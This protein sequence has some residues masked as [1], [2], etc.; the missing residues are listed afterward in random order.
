M[1]LNFFYKAG[2]L[3]VFFRGLGEGGGDSDQESD[4]PRHPDSGSESADDESSGESSQADSLY[5]V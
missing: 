2:I 5:R 3:I 1:L 4:H